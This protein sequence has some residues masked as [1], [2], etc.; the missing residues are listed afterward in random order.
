MSVSV[1]PKAAA[2][3]A[4]KP[5]SNSARQL[6]GMSEAAQHR[7]IAKELNSL[8]RELEKLLVRSDDMVKRSAGIG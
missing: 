7:W 2:K 5:R 8:N 6:Q 4:G 3:P 1:A